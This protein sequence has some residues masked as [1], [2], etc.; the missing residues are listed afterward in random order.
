MCR[1]NGETV[2]ARQVKELAE[3][4]I[5]LCAFVTLFK[6]II[7]KALTKKKVQGEDESRTTGKED[8]K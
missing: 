5:Y 8:E 1:I 2:T 6:G 4:L 7:L 3:L